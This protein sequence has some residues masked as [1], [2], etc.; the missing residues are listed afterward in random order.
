LPKITLFYTA[1]GMEELAGGMEELAAVVI[2]GEEEYKED[3]RD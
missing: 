3:D 2:C 1:A